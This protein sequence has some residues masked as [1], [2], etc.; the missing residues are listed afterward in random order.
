MNWQNQVGP[1]LG[2][3]DGW[4]KRTYQRV[5]PPASF[6]NPPQE[7][8]V[9]PNPWS[10]AGNSRPATPG[11]GWKK[12]QTKGPKT[13]YGWDCTSLACCCVSLVSFL[14]FSEL[15]CELPLQT[16]FGAFWG[17]AVLKLRYNI[18]HP[19]Q[20]HPPSNTSMQEK[21]NVFT[22]QFGAAE[23]KK[24]R[25]RERAGGRTNPGELGQHGS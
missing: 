9:S 3:Q 16:H 12:Y 13:A 23:P 21:E 19:L 7:L 2:L 1:G 18:A 20:V 5:N 4:G 17:K 15:R 8:V 25:Q 24:I 6:W 14:W 22:R 10:F 11:R